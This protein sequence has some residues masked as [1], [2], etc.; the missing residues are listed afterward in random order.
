MGKELGIYAGSSLQPINRPSSQTDRIDDILST[1]VPWGPTPH[2]ELEHDARRKPGDIKIEDRA[3]RRDLRIGRN[4]NLQTGEVEFQHP[5]SGR[6]WGWCTR[7]I[8]GERLP[9]VDPRR[10]SHRPGRERRVLHETPP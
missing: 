9:Q 8:L 5:A 10:Q 3:A 2:I 1:R 6:L 4:P 7:S